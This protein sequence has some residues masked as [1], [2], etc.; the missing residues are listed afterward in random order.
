MIFRWMSIIFKRLTR[1]EI[2]SRLKNNIWLKEN[3]KKILSTSGAVFLI[4][5]ISFSIYT[6][7]RKNQQSQI[8]ISAAPLIEKAVD[9]IS[10]KWNYLDTQSLLSNI[11]IRKVGH[12]I[13]ILEN[14]SRLGKL[15]SQDKPLRL[16]TDPAPYTAT[17]S[18]IISYKVLATFENGQAV[19]LFNL[20]D[21]DGIAAINYL[22]IDA[23]Y[24]INTRLPLSMEQLL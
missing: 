24:N 19:F 14:F 6:V 23:V 20:A 7:I 4:F 13:H 12:N 17:T 16:E 18:I 5:I 21:Q 9:T 11:L 22:N 3:H 2:F 10:D 1:L 15:I 8:Q